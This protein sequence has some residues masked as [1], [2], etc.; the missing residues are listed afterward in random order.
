MFPQKKMAGL[1][2]LIF[3][4]NNINVKETLDNLG[5]KLLDR[6]DYWQTNALF[7]GG[8]N[9]TAIQIYKDTGVWKDH[10]NQTPFMPFKKLVQATLGSNDDE[11][12]EGA[13]FK[14]D[15]FTD[16][17]KFNNKPRISME[18]TYNDSC[19]SRLLPHYCFY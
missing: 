1:I 5:Y 11:I 13:I 3:L 9:R 18:K 19:L 14:Q 15:L 7:R 10:V 2:Y 6:G 8:D 17:V 12:I 16:A 4:M